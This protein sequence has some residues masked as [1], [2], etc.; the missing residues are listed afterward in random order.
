[1]TCEG[2]SLVIQCYNS[3]YQI[4]QKFGENVKINLAKTLK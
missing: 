4:A 2:L 1:M 3:N